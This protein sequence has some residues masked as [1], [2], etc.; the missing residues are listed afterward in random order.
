MASLSAASFSSFIFNSLRKLHE[1]HEIKEKYFKNALLIKI[2][3]KIPKESPS[4]FEI[5]QFLL[6]LKQ[7]KRQM[8][9]N[10]LKN[11]FLKTRIFLVWLLSVYEHLTNRDFEAFVIKLPFFLIN[12]I[13]F[14][15]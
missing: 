3:L 6:F 13:I 8:K 7:F 9:K 14:R 11:F 5:N 15:Q 10:S 1:T 12:F 4:F 2:S